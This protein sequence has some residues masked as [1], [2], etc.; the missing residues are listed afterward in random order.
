MM[1]SMKSTATPRQTF[2]AGYG[3]SRLHERVHLWTRATP[4]VIV[5]AQLALWV[6]A[7]GEQ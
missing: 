3:F 6:T 1:S 7:M 5:Q 4:I 2:G